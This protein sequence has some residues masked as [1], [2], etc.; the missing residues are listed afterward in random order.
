MIEAALLLAGGVAGYWV[1]WLVDEKF[2]ER[3]EKRER[4]GTYAQMRLEKLVEFLGHRRAN[5]QWLNSRSEA[6]LTADDS[7]TE[8]M[9]QAVS[10]WIHENR[11]LYPSDI[12]QA[13]SSIMGATHM[14]LDVGGPGR[15]YVSSPEGQMQVIDAWQRLESYKAELEQELHGSP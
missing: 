10:G 2:T 3:R 12:E 13:L 15:R 14:L 8:R 1:R 6:Q 5:F 7:E 11:P 9:V 4:R